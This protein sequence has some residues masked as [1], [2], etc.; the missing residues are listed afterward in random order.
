MSSIY[1]YYSNREFFLNVF[2]S[3][4]L[5]FNTTGEYNDP[6]EKYAFFTAE[7]DG[8]S[9]II[10]P[11]TKLQQCS[12][13]CFSTSNLNYLLWSYYGR[14]HKGFCLELN[15]T[16]CIKSTLDDNV[17]IIQFYN[18]TV[19]GFPVIYGCHSAHLSRDKLLKNVMSTKESIELIRYKYPFWQYEQE[20]RL[21]S[22][23]KGPIQIRIP[24]NAIKSITYG[25]ETDKEDIAYVDSKLTELGFDICHQ[26]ITTF[27]T[28][29]GQLVLG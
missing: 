10:Y 16:D 9:Y 24:K 23:L 21:L 28:Y 4:S 5:Y 26:K 19:F 1:K 25:L 20:F 6:V 15:L 8:A 22:F 11:E 13:C 2:E 3:K 27:D 17:Q 12:L 14:N 18:E 7:E 29:T